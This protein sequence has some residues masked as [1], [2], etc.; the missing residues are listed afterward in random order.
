M[1]K[2]ERNRACLVETAHVIAGQLHVRGTEIVI[3]LLA[4]ARA[5]DGNGTPRRDPGDRDLA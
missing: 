1:R 3:E 4:R 5:D 2:A